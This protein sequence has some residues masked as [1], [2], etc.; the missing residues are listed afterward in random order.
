MTSGGIT[1]IQNGG[2]V[3]NAVDCLSAGEVTFVES[4]AWK[5]CIRC[6]DIDRLHETGNIFEEN[7]AS[8]SPSSKC[9]WKTN[10]N[11]SGRRRLWVQVYYSFIDFKFSF[12]STLHGYMHRPTEALWI[13]KC[14]CKTNSNDLWRL[15]VHRST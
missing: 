11:N 5:I 1:T 12:G 15:H 2:L 9:T 3:F 6:M 14:T 7:S 4:S 10:S 13:S 8:G